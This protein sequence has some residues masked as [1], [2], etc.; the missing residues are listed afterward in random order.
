M[1]ASR[2]ARR[3]GR[4]AGAAAHSRA[5]EQGTAGT[6]KFVRCVRALDAAIAHGQQAGARL[7]TLRH[8]GSD[9]DGR[10]DRGRRDHNSRRPHD[11]GR[12][13]TPW[14]IGFDLRLGALFV[15][16]RFGGR[17]L[18]RARIS[19]RR[20]RWCC[21]WRRH[22]CWRCRSWRRRGSGGG[23]CRWRG[24]WRCRLVGLGR[25]RCCAIRAW[26]GFGLLRLVRSLREG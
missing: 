7:R 18:R 19:H 26:C 9:P 5:T 10:R 13:A 16:L 4:A 17:R 23:C 24:R 14:I 21:W 3:A 2:P 12:A 22:R 15:W 1:S 20:R 25:R 11:D 8:T 6:P